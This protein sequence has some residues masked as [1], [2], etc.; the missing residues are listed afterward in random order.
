MVSDHGEREVRPACPFCQTIEG[1]EAEWRY[2]E[3]I[4][5][6]YRKICLFPKFFLNI[7]PL[8][9]ACVTASVTASAACIVFVAMIAKSGRRATVAIEAVDKSCRDRLDGKIVAR[10][11]NLALV[12][13]SAGSGFVRI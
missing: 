7:G 6:T 2:G 4:G 3:G 11:R 10:V 5:D 9:T 8:T 1:F 12:F 13:L